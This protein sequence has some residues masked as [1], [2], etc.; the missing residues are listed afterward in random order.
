VQRGDLHPPGDGEASGDPTEIALLHAAE[1]LGAD[2][3]VARRADARRAVFAFDAARKRMTTVD[4]VDGGR[5]VHVKGAPDQLL[6]RCETIATAADALLLD[7]V[8]RAEVLESVD[9][10]PRVGFA[11]SA[12]RVRDDDAGG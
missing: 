7:H 12:L 9:V 4:E 1:L 10:L 8:R 6:E 3:R 11:S 5:W 2:V